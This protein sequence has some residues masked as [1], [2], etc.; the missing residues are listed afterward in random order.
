MIDIP[1]LANCTVLPFDHPLR[2]AAGAVWKAF[3]AVTAGPV[4][5]AL[6]ALLEV[7]RRSPLAG[8]K[9]LVRKA[10]GAFHRNDDELARR[11][12]E[13]VPADA[14]VHRLSQVLL[15]IIDQRPVPPGIASVLAERLLPPKV[16]FRESLEKV[17]QELE[18][19]WL[20][21]LTEALRSAMQACLAAAPDSAERL[22][23]HMAIRCAMVD[24]PVEE[25]IRTIGR[26][27]KDAYYSPLLA[28]NGN[29]RV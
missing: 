17:E 26:P 8:W 16:S 9:S 7:S 1:A 12:I 29:L 21:R 13:Q 3:E 18:G 11:A 24:V 6:L 14:A 15:A 22:R 25:V 27:R 20:N 4:D 28:G 23:Q 2:V 10:S 19:Q 5:E